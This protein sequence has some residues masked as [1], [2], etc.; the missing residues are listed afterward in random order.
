M[1]DKAHHLA[2]TGKFFKLDPDAFAHL[3]S[4]AECFCSFTLCARNGDAPEKGSQ[5]WAR[6][7]LEVADGLLSSPQSRCFAL[8]LEL[9]GYQMLLQMLLQML[10]GL[11]ILQPRLLV[12]DPRWPDSHHWRA[13]SLVRLQQREEARKALKMAQLCAEE[14]CVHSWR[15]SSDQPSYL[16]S[17]CTN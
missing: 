11:V 17:D 10:S 9:I 1:V 16:H 7:A 15:E 12:E 6:K 3:A 2:S 13:R 4:F 14:P 8:C 5:E